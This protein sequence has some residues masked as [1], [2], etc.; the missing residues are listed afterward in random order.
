[1][2]PKYSRA[3]VLR[4]FGEP[5]CIEDVEAPCVIEPG[6]LLVRVDVGTICGTDVHMSMGSLRM[7][8]KLPIILG[9]EMVGRIVAAGA[10]VDR[11]SVGQSLSIGDRIVWT[12]T[13]CGSCFFCTAARQP[14]L[15]VHRRGYMYECIDEPPHLLGGFTEYCYVLPDS[16]RIRVPDAVSDEVASLASCALR[17]VVNG[18]DQ[19]GPIETTDYVVIQGVGPLGLLAA[20]S[21]KALGA[22]KIIVIGAPDNRLELA[23]D[24][25]A[26]VCISIEKTTREER[27]DLVRT[28]TEGRGADIVME[29]T[30]HP[31]AFLEGADLARRGGRYLVMGQVGTG[32]V[33][34]MPSVFVMKNLRVIGSFAGDAR[35]YWK[36]LE[37]AAKHKEDI[38]FERMITGR[39]DLVDVN[40]ALSRMKDALEIKPL[41][42]IQR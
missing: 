17:S 2:L 30:G 28:L 27:L 21:A 22:K 18:L 37:F 1:M 16:R 32:T 11:D 25:G 39:F 34:F 12:H 23:E 4:T 42:R 10:G 33:E 5:L 7:N 3:A 9:H 35:T 24:F 26:D 38:P 6:A 15:C 13:A 31:E 14:A 8:V 19:L 36:A 29:F 40:L 41:L 20:A